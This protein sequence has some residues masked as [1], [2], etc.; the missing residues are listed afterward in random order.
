MSQDDEIEA[1]LNFFATFSLSRPISS[2]VDLAD[3]ALL[4]EVLSVVYGS[5]PSDSVNTPN[6][7]S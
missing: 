6:P 5:L 1:F 7:I 3:G 4:F 2:I